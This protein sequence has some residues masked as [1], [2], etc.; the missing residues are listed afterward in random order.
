MSKVA[1]WWHNEIRTN[2]GNISSKYYPDIL[3]WD[4]TKEQIKHMYNEEKGIS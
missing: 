4:L 3:P 1:N 2:S